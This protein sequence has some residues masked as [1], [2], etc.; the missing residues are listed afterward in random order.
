M[1]HPFR[2]VEE[3]GIPA[4]PERQDW[5]YCANFAPSAE[6]RA[7]THWLIRTVTEAGVGEYFEFVIEGHE[8]APQRLHL[9]V[10]ASAG[11][12]AWN[13][14]QQLME[15]ER[16]DSINDVMLRPMVQKLWDEMPLADRVQV[17]LAAGENPQSALGPKVPPGAFELLADG[18]RTPAPP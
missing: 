16:Q 13:L 17:A 18:L 9:V 8:E 3:T 10:H 4:P 12:A 15:P 14:L 1:P 7:K 6:D 2:T 5:L 11:D